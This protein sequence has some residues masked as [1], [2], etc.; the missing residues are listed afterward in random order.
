M[1]HFDVLTI[2]AA[3][4]I[5][6]LA[7]TVSG[8]M[9]PKKG[10]E[11]DQQFSRTIEN[12]HMAFVA[13]RNASVLLT[14]YAG[15]ADA[16]GF[17]PLASMF[18][19]IAQGERIHAANCAAVLELLGETPREMD[20]PMIVLSTAE[21][22][23]SAIATQGYE[24][25]VMYPEFVKQARKENHEAAAQVFRHNMAAEP[26][27]HALF[28]QALKD[29]DGYKGVNV[30]FVVCSGCGFAARTLNERVC[31]VCSAPENRFINVK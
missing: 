22:L 5:A 31:P 1:K 20:D 16:E 19:A 3:L 25:D 2:S 8:Q 24:S 15:K 12:L 9:P 18:R 17:G 4:A 28:Q 11:A 13:E 6:C 14:M 26:M 30:E 27:H 7:A 21:N 10:I 29:L 23:A